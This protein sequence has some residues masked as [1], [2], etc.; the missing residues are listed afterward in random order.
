MEGDEVA[1]CGEDMTR[2]SPPE[3][4]QR[5]L[6]AVLRARDR[7][8]IVGDLL[9]EFRE[10]KLPR[11]GR[12]RANYWYVRQI[13]SFASIRILGGQV[14]KQAWMLLSVFA[15]AAGLWLAVMEQVLKHPGYEGRSIVD[16]CIVLQ[17][18]AT[19]LVVFFSGSSLLRGVVMTGAVA[20]ALL[21]AF[22]IFRILQS[23]HFEGYVLLIGSALLLQGGLTVAMVLKAGLLRTAR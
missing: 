4:L 15:A 7:E 18:C 23:P 8:T 10:E 5:T 20:M 14:V 6:T 19:L 9:E 21:G 16:A 1:D 13:L 12:T 17:A 22:A 3:W 2:Q 11:F